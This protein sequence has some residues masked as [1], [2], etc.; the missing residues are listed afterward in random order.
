MILDHI[1]PGDIVLR[2]VG[3]SVM[4]AMKV[5]GITEDL[6]ICGS[7]KFDRETGM[8]EDEDLG[9][10]VAHGRT[11]TKLVLANKHDND[12]LVKAVL[13]QAPTT[14]DKVIDAL[15]AIQSTDNPSPAFEYERKRL[16]VLLENVHGNPARNL[17]R[18]KPAN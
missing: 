7:W 10:G 12:R 18:E 15:L 4:M 16:E 6:I 14:Y 2:A 1:K 8:E 9:W 13:C 11:G 17:A 5:T 3:E